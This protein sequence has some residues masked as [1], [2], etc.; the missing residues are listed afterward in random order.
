[1]GF[2][3]LE[4]SI[5]KYVFIAALIGGI[6]SL[7]LGKWTVSLG[8]LVGAAVSSLN[9]LSLARSVRRLVRLPKSQ[10]TTMATKGYVTRLLSA[11]IVLG[12]SAYTRNLG[13]FVG[14]VVGYFLIKFVITGLGILGKVD[15][16]KDFDL[17]EREF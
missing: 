10:A 5:I 16:G 4:V 13:F 1:M 9:F 17:D 7:I 8:L 11:C 2:K 3:N 14:T 6:I 15:L 12:A